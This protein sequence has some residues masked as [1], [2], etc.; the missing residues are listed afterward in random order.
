MPG[1][2]RAR[3]ERAGI[4]PDRDAV[5]HLARRTEGN[6]LAAQQEIDK[7]ALLADGGT[8][9]AEDVDAAVADSARYTVFRFADEA[10]AGRSER[11][12]RM[13][14][15]LQREGVAPVLVLWALGKELRQLAI[16][17]EAV[18]GGASTA[19]V[20]AAHRVWSSRK[21]L[22][23]AALARLEP[24]VLYRLVALSERADRAAKGQSGEDAWQL[25][26][27]LTAGLA[28][29]RLVGEAA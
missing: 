13:L 28:S 8:L 10:L 25:L 16:M 29:G 15:G 22:V 4:R 7:L 2:I 6:L 1:W 20:I 5:L 18:A 19:S 14:G 12:L 21:G 23:Q 11:A 17:R 9:S 27:R 26:V 3:C 24:G